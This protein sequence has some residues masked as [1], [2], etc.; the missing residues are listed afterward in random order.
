[1]IFLRK[2]KD[3]EK[4]DD[5]DIPA[6]KLKEIQKSKKHKLQRSSKSGKSEQSQP[7]KPAEKKL[8][9]LIE[10]KYED[11]PQKKRKWGT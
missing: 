9:G 4:V 10:E 2:K 7:E 11:S 1:M 3:F 6:E 5:D 8:S